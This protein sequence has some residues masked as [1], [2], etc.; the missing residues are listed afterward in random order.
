[1]Q[2]DSVEFRWNAVTGAAHYHLHV[3][4]QHEGDETTLLDNDL[5]VTQVKVQLVHPAPVQWEL[6]AVDAQGKAGESA[7]SPAGKTSK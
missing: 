2:T 4:Q 6:Q 1:M 7:R 3:W 5:E